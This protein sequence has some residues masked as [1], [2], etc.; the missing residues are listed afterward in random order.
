[1]HSVFCKNV[2]I[3]QNR[4]PY[5]IAEI[6]VNH[7]GSLLKAKKLIDLAASSGAH[8]AKFQTYKADSFA[9]IHSPPYWDTKKEKSKS[10]H[11]LFKKYDSFNQQDYKELYTHCKLKKIDFL[12]TPFDTDSLEFLNPILKFYKI[13]S[14]DINNLP[15]LKAIASKK[16][17]VV[18]STGAATIKEIKYAVNFLTKSGC[19]DVSLLHCILNYPTKYENANL[20][21]IKSLIK[22]FPKNTI[23]YSDH[24]L[25][26]E[27]MLT[28]LTSFLKGARIIEKH[29]TYNKKLPGND[30]YHAMD[31][32]DLKIF[33]KN[34]YKLKSI[35]GKK[36]K[37]PLL[38][39]KPAI[40]NARRSIVLN[41][42][43]V[44]G[45]KIN[46]KNLIA[47][48][49]GTGIPPQEWN[50]IIGKKVNKNLK[51]DHILS[52]KDIE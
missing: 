31:S 5:I 45:S 10:Q 14:A 23:G 11:A 16:K 6:G 34:L 9:S 22:F 8:A 20:D 29:F 17:P 50:N 32:K 47:K 2:D 41:N 18:L 24:T 19:P 48:R 4:I 40:I 3:A 25:P 37:K 26:D 49:P 27:Q 36:D 52:Y 38:S 43:V 46:E 12:S 30:H 51:K 28:L 1:M 15:L 13:A 39:E 35:S 21:M 33:I 42:D 44:K 7:E